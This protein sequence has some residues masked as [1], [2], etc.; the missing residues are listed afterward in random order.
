MS[1]SRSNS[2]SLSGTGPSVSREGGPHLGDGRP[3]RRPGSRASFFVFV[4]TEE[5]FFGMSSP[6]SQKNLLTDIII[7]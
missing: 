2:D 6:F 1:A 7:R 3:L 4:K 5:Y